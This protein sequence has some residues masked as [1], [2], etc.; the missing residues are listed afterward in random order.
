M[1]RCLSCK[2]QVCF[3][4]L[5]LCFW[6]N[7]PWTFQ[8]VSLW[9]R[10]SNWAERCCSSCIWFS[11]EV[12]LEGDQTIQEIIFC[13]IFAS[14][15]LYGNKR[16]FGTAVVAVKVY[17]YADM[18]QMAGLTSA[19]TLIPPKRNCF[20]KRLCSSWFV[21]EAREENIGWGMFEGK[22]LIIC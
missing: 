2:A 14:R 4:T 20:S 11:H 19:L 21:V 5:Q 17:Q 7:S 10:W 13:V 12:L 3:N 15:F 9:T 18:M 16:D 8:V 6:E 22:W 1:Y